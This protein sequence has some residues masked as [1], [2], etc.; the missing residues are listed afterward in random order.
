MGSV[1]LGTFWVI[2]LLFT[3]W[4]SRWLPRAGV[5]RVR[6]GAGNQG[7]ESRGEGVLEPP[8]PSAVHVTTSRQ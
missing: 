5:P 8:P 1:W 6:V 7:E 3:K 2:E 4:P